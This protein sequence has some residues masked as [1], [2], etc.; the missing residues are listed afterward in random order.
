[1]AALPMI[2]EEIETDGTVFRVN[3]GRVSEPGRVLIRGLVSGEGD[4]VFVLG[5]ERVLC[6]V[7]G[8]VDAEHGWPCPIQVA[9]VKTVSDLMPG[10]HRH[11]VIYRGTDPLAMS[12][13]WSEYELLTKG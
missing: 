3:M 1:M 7:F 12:I 10:I 4:I 2:L 5:P 9:E 6:G 13:C 8:L 11:P